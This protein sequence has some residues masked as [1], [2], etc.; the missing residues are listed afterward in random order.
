MTNIKSFIPHPP[1]FPHLFLLG[2]WGGLRS[3]WFSEPFLTFFLFWG[4]RIRK[5]E[6]EG[7]RKR[8]WGWGWGFGGEGTEICDVSF[9]FSLV[10]LGG[11]GRRTSGDYIVYCNLRGNGEMEREE[12]VWVFE[13]IGRLIE[14]VTDT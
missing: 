1:P 14:S 11:G 9:C 2:G 5:G 4:N 10:W 6:G 3:F 13:K 12:I 8:K 7:E